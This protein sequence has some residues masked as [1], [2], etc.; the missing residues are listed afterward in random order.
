VSNDT[1]EP[2]TFRNDACY[3]KLID[4]FSG[5]ILDGATKYE[6]KGDVPASQKAYS[7]IA[8]ADDSEEYGILMNE[9]FAT[10]SSSCSGGTI[11]GQ[12]VLGK[13]RV[14]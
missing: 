13:V 9:N 1:E 8:K 11:T 4:S 14:S 3:Q 12:N 7:V 10:V 2:K 5:P 6:T